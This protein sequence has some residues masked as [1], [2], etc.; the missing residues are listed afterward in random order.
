[1]AFSLSKALPALALLLASSSAPAIAG[2]HKFDSSDEGGFYLSVGGGV[3]QITSNDWDYAVEGK[4]QFEG[5]FEYDS[6]FAFE[7]GLG[8]DFGNQF[9]LEATYLTFGGEVNS[10][11]VDTTGSYST[12][13]VGDIYV[14]AAMATAYYDF[15]TDSQ[16]TPYIGGGAGFGTVNTV[17][18]DIG[19]RE[20]YGDAHQTVVYQFKL[21]VSYEVADNSDLF[22][23][24]TYAGT[25]HVDAKDIDYGT[26]TA[27]GGRAG[28]RFS[29]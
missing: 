16:I 10:S 24:G 25:G 15:K 13:D 14:S 7:G 23:E 22:L 11:T 20:V 3:S 5:D 9:R 2:G 18:G 21:G 28:L 4:K 29:F 27:W 26:I 12:T 6:R 1:M 19:G 8:Y 17:D